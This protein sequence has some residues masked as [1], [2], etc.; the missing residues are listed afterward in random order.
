MSDNSSVGEDVEQ[1]EL[2]YVI[3]VGYI[4]WYN[5]FKKFLHGLVELKIN[6]PHG[7]RIPFQAKNSIEICVYVLQDPLPPKYCL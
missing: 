6:I 3:V 1:Q 2:L 7:P 4:N 5:Y